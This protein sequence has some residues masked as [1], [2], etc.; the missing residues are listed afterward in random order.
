MRVSDFVL[1]LPYLE[2][3]GDLNLCFIN[4]PDQVVRDGG[5][6]VWGWRCLSEVGGLIENQA[7]HCVWESPEGVLWEITPQG[8]LCGDQVGVLRLP[9]RFI[10]DD[11]VRQQFEATGEIGLIG[12]YRPLHPSPKVQKLCELVQREQAAWRDGDAERHRYWNKRVNDIAHKFGF[13]VDPLA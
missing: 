9:S 5:R 10:P 12:R 13:H 6:T 11:A 3:G 1:D 7:G 2:V 4:V 8:W